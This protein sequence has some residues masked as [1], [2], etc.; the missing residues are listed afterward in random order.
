MRR[1]I[2][3]GTF[4][5]LVLGADCTR[6]VEEHIRGV[7]EKTVREGAC[8][9]ITDALNEIYYVLKTPDSEKLCGQYLGQRVLLT[10]SVEPRGAEGAYFLN[11]KK[12]EPWQPK[13]P[14]AKTD[15]ASSGTSVP[16]PP[17][18]PPPVPAPKA[19]APGQ[20]SDKK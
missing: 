3:A 7:L 18:P 8:A 19:D 11:V 16:L 14:G 17:P 9:Q 5:V 12:A 1:S 20:N 10:G 4:L 2:L 6:A 15:D 13:Q